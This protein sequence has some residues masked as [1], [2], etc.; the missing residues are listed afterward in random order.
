MPL[1]HWNRNSKTSLQE[2]A[3]VIATDINTKSLEEL[4]KEFSNYKDKLITEILMS[5]IPTSG[6]IFTRAKSQ[7]APVLWFN[8][9]CRRN[10][11][12]L[13]N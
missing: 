7:S 6:K 11:T 10:F 4:K 2:G 8:Q 13:Y 1:R 12:R 3:I 9:F 5:E